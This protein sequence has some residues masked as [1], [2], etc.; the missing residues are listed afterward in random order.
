VCACVDSVARF[1]GA[2]REAQFLSGGDVPAN[3]TS[4]FDFKSFQSVILDAFK[5]I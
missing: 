1:D 2:V 4:K 5:E 3:T